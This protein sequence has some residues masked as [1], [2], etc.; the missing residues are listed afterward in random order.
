MSTHPGEA[1][2]DAPATNRPSTYSWRSR[3]PREARDAGGRK[4]RD[5]GAHYQTDG[6]LPRRP[7]RSQAVSKT[8]LQLISSSSRSKFRIALSAVFVP[9][10]IRCRVL[11]IPHLPGCPERS[12]RIPPSPCLPVSLSAV[13]LLH[14]W[15]VPG[16]YSRLQACSLRSRRKLPSTS[17]GRMCHI[18][19]RPLFPKRY[20]KITLLTYDAT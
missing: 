3:P 18:P 16:P 17:A 19:N 12:R 13:P 8:A 4:P 11:R 9:F 6:T 15:P 20:P 7:V 10:Q 2:L 1:I 14:T 5:R